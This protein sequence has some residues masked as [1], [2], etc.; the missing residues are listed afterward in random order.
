MTAQLETLDGLKRK[1]T[2]TVDGAAL[3]KASEKKIN[4]AAGSVQMKGFRPGKVPASVIQQ[5]F[6]R[7]ILID[8]AASLIDSTF[9]TEIESQQIKLAGAPQIDFNHEAVK[10]GE[11]FQYAATFEVYPTITLKD[12]TDVEIE[13]ASGEVTDVDLSAMLIKMRAQ[14]AEW[15]VADRAAKLGDRVKIDFDGMLDGKPMENGSAKDHTLELGSHSM[16]PGFEDGI[17]GMKKDET[18]TIN[19]AFPAEY[20][21]E[22]LRSKPVAF[23]ITVHDIQEP[24]LPPLDD[25][26]AKKL[27]VNDG[28]DALKKQVMERMQLEMNE[29][30]HANTKEAVLDKLMSLNT[31]EVPTAL[32]DMEIQHLQNVTRQQMRQY[33]GKDAKFDV[34]KFPLTREP[35][36]VDAKKRVILGLLLAEVIKNA[37]ITVDPKKV[38]ERLHR[39]AEQYGD[40]TQILPIIQKNKQMIADVEAYVLEEQA[41]QTLLSKARVSEVKKSYDSIMNSNK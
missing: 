16:I 15:I 28:V 27:G 40:I 4:D 19:V 11:S 1:I 17:I 36:E 18:K 35:Y 38:E 41:V 23:T 33:M 29:K 34:D 22:S 3:K 30:A 5:K 12:L 14:H 21:V 32:I 6:G 37:A 24:K 9:K 39:I 31:I 25:E 13:S 26:F 10:P 7:S 20:H 2:I 8:A